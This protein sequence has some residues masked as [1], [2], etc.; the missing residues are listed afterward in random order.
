MGTLSRALA[1]GALVTSLAVLALDARAD[2]HQSAGSPRGRRA[3]AELVAAESAEEGFVYVVVARDTLS[4]IALRFEVTVEG[5]LAHNPGMHPDRVRVGQRL[6]IVNG[7]RRVLHEVARGES[8]ALV[9]GRYEVRIDEVLRWNAGLRRDRLRAGRQLVVYTRV[10]ESRSLSVG[11]PDAG[12]LEHGRPLP[13]EHPA[14]Y[15][16]TPERAYGTDE[17]VRWIVEAFDVVR[18]ADPEAPRVEV[19]DLSFREGGPIDGHHSHESGRDADLAYYQ[20]GCRD[21]CRFRR[22]RPEHLDV[23]RQWALFAH[24]IQRGVVEHIFMDHDL[25]AALYEHARS[26]GVSRADLSR[27]FQ[28]PRPVEQRYGIIRHHPQHAD[29]FHVRFVCHESDPDCR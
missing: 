20:R 27:W 7:L 18:R 11:S 16:R 21:L 25:A 4:D 2:E 29:H 26:V 9:A 10:P 8:L 1:L 3:A 22:I 23:A 5:I 24:W 6:R 19:H 13:T 28:Y 17:T 12:Q 15:V 14:F